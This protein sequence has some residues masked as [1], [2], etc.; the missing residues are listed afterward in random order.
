MLG[1]GQS[2]MRFCPPL[3]IERET[4]QQGLEIFDASLTQAEQDAGLL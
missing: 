1:C 2:A 4:V 3:M